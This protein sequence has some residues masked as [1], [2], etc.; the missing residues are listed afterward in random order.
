MWEKLLL[1]RIENSD[2]N[3]IS[4]KKGQALGLS[5]YTTKLSAIILPIESIKPCL[6]PA[7]EA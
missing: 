4:T 7:A 3:S 1:Q 6:T 5:F 2:I